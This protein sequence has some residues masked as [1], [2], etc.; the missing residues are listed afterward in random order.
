VRSNIGVIQPPLDR[1]PQK[2]AV[3]LIDATHHDCHACQRCRYRRGHG[4]VDPPPTS[5]VTYRFRNLCRSR[6]V[7]AGDHDTVRVLGREFVR[8][9]SPD[10]AI[11]TYDENFWGTH[12]VSPE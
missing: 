2:A 9:A 11:A 8:N 5:A 12:A 3:G 4:N 10:H 1:C 6:R 7:T